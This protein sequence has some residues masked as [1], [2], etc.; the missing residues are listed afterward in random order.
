MSQAVAQWQW[1][2]RSRKEVGQAMARNAGNL[3]K[4]EFMIVASMKAATYTAAICSTLVPWSS[5]LAATSASVGT[6]PPMGL[7]FYRLNQAA[8]AN[9]PLFVLM[10]FSL[11]FLK[12]IWAFDISRLFL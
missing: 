12:V 9:A 1:S 3:S 7:F 8:I 11:S 5:A 4:V 6:V 2:L 10:F